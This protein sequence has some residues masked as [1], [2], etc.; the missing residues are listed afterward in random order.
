MPA[1]RIVE[2]IYSGIRKSAFVIVDVTEPKPNVYYELG[3]ARGLGIPVIITA[4]E[5]TEL[6][7]DIFDL[8]VHFWT[9]SKSLKL[10][11]KKYVGELA[12]NFGRA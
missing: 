7:F 1:D 3:Y 6:P 4:K 5:G 2:H 10:K 8:P 12:K 11:L 9:N